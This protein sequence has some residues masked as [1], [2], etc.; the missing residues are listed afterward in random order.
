MTLRPAFLL[1]LL[2]V[3]LPAHAGTVL[4]PDA[5]DPQD[6]SLAAA[7]LRSLWL[8]ED[9]HDL[10]LSM[11]LES[12]PSPASA[13]GAEAGRDG[14][15][16]SLRFRQGPA[17]WEWRE[18]LKTVYLPDGTPGVQVQDQLL[19]N[20]TS[21]GPAQD[22]V[23]D[24]QAFPA[25][26][27][28]TSDPLFGAT[29]DTTTGVRALQFLHSPDAIPEGAV[30][31]NL[32]ASVRSLA[33]A[34]LNTVPCDALK[35]M[36]CA[37]APAQVY[38][39]GTPPPIPGLR[40]AT[41]PLELAPGQSGNATLLLNNTGSAAHELGFAARLPAGWQVRFT[42]P[43]LA[44]AAGAQASVQATVTAPAN[45]TGAARIALSGYETGK[46]ATAALEVEVQP[47]APPPAE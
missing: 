32:T 8:E 14:L 34:T 1:L 43:T 17:A 35:A 31:T 33:D 19:R 41:T 16:F 10:V 25:G 6:A 7:D 11:R 4:D 9:S 12:V 42:P 22:P 26:L 47:P 38:V 3:P 39:V 29:Q 13:A 23:S 15:Q 46:A 21:V 45:A 27:L 5:S 20:G 37:E 40:A 18:T 36:D 2:L 44:L 28:G 24:A 30:L